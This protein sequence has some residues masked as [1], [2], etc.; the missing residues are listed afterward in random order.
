MSN[1]KIKNVVFNTD[2]FWKEIIMNHEIAHLNA[3]DSY[4]FSAK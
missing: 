3:T 4:Y 1:I 2:L